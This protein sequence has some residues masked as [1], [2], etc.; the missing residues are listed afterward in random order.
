MCWTVGP[1]RYE[2]RRL[3]P[4]LDGALLGVE[5]KLATNY[6]DSVLCNRPCVTLD[7]SYVYINR[8]AMSVYSRIIIVRQARLLGFSHYDLVVDQL[9]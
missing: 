8:R 9:L 7:P 5:G 4:C 3:Y 6:E 2:D 1:W